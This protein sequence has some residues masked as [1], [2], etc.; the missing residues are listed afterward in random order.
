M[1]DFIQGGGDI[2]KAAFDFVEFR[3]NF[4]KTAELANTIKGIDTQ[5]YTA[6]AIVRG[7]GSGIEAL[8][9]L[10]ILEAV[11][12]LK[13]PFISAIGHPD[14]KLFIKELADR[15][16][17]VPNDLGHYF[18]DMM[19]TVNEKKTKSRAVLTE[20]IKKQ[21]KDQLEAGQ[22]QNK[23]LQEKLTK[24]TKTQEETQK[25]HKEQVDKANKQ[26]EELQKKLTE[27]T[28][29]NETA[30]KAHAEQLGKLQVQLKAQTEASS[31]QSKEFNESLKKMQETN[32]QLQ[33]S[34]E[35]LTAQNTQANKD[36]NEAKDK[37]RQLEKQ[38]SEALSNS[39]S[40]L[41]KIIAI[42]AAIAFF[43]V[44]LFK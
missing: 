27:I 26:N 30:Q 43:A 41:W 24:L 28:K 9:E 44:L 10:D 16:V 22:K 35:K 17:S 21:F 7:G 36:L 29:A 34:M 32:G 33:K 2:A 3:A 18:K 6:I 23:E 12:N 15:E 38:L 1:T 42:I 13:T 25:Q 40:T 14:E 4:S 11:A 20:Q 5:S 31:K 37:A 39:G 19:E 8:D